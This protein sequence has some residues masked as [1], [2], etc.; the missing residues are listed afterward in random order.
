MQ[1][2]K[3]AIKSKGKGIGSDIVQVGSFLNHRIDTELMFQMGEYIA[4][5]FQDDRPDLVMTV[6][7]SGIALAMA[8]AHALNDLPILF[9]KKN[10]A[11]NQ[12]EEMIEEAVTSFTKGTSYQMRCVKEHL[13]QGA[14]VLIVDDFLADGEA[15]RGMMSLVQ[16][17][18]AET[19]GVAIAIEKGFQKGGAALRAQGVKLLSLS[20]V[21][22]IKDGDILLLED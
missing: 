13:P 3:E 6:E 15:V 9:A 1:Q 11:K 14:R 8:I 19:V 7:A 21:R 22:E 4:R 2:L 18:Q 20:V 17:A 10:P 16:K 5:H 12:N